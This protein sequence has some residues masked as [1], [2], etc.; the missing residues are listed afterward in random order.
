LLWERAELDPQLPVFSF[1]DLVDQI[2][3]YFFCARATH[4]DL[5]PRQELD[6]EKSEASDSLTFA[7]ITVLAACLF[8]GVQ[9]HLITP[10]VV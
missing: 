1:L 8:D 10:M 7:C 2:L 6:N 4:P 5:R 3:P 9:G